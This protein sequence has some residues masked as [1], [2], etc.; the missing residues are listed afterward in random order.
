MVFHYVKRRYLG[1]TSHGCKQRKIKDYTELFILITSVIF[2]NSKQ[3]LLYSPLGRTYIVQPDKRLSPPHPLLP[4]GAAFYML[5][6]TYAP[7]KSTF[8]SALHAFLNSPHP[9]ETLSDLK[10]YGSDGTILR[11]HESSN[12]FRA[13]DGVLRLHM[14]KVVRRSSRSEESLS[15]WWPFIAGH[16]KEDGIVHSSDP[17]KQLVSEV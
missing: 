11:D 1:N 2:V 14:R 7:S 12:Y 8:A 17:G 4:E 5:E 6:K 9:L 3:R 13:I 10:A 15:N 16:H